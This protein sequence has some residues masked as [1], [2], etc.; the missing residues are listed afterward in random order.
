MATTLILFSFGPEIVEHFRSLSV[1]K[2]V[3]ASASTFLGNKY[4]VD[5]ICFKNL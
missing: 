1:A 4:P 5:G 3:H 2:D